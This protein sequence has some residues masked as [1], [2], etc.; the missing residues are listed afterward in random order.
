MPRDLAV[1]EHAQKITG[2]LNKGA[3]G[4]F[5]PVLNRNRSK[6][7]DGEGGINA[8]RLSPIP[9]THLSPNLNKQLKPPMSSQQF[10]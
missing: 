2:I 3:A 5:L 6:E 10:S 1:K 8:S 9:A 4:A 7:K